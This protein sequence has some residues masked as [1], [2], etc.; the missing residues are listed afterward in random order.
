MCVLECC[1]VCHADEAKGKEKEEEATAT[2]PK[3]TPAAPEAA[4]ARNKKVLTVAA[5]PTGLCRVCAAW[6]VCLCH[7]L[8][9][10]AVWQLNATK[11]KHRLALVSVHVTEKRRGGMEKKR[12]PRWRQQHPRHLQRVQQRQCAR[13][14]CS[15]WLQLPQVCITAV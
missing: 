12:Y 14:R 8:S 10:F 7:G 4:P 1:F 13:R 6:D 3:K 11:S 15:L 5:A 9:R 2:S